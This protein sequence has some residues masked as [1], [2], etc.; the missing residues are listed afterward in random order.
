MRKLLLIP[1]LLIILFMGCA[2]SG[3]NLFPDKEYCPP[4]QAKDS[5]ILKWV[6][7]G[8]TDTALMTATALYLQKRPEK[9][10]EVV[11]VAEFILAEIDRPDVT[12][13]L[14]QLAIVKKLGPLMYVA[15]TPLLERFK[16]INL[17][18]GACDRKL[19]KGQ[20]VKQLNLAKM[21]Q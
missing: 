18:I 1:T 8:W 2:N 3:M 4:E 19:I 20:A 6:D 7:P 17:I 10:K 5:Y 14:F 15:A 13:D 21:V 16:G 12:Y 9:A 11:E